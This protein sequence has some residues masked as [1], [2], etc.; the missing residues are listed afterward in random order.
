M[1]H[2]VTCSALHSS[3][4]S[5]GVYL[6]GRVCAR[7]LRG[8]THTE[9]EKSVISGQHLLHRLCPSCYLAGTHPGLAKFTSCLETP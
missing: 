7:R 8:P 9:T 1:R 6:M 3:H 2:A 5:L 4:T